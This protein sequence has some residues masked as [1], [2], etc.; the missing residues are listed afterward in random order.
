MPVPLRGQEREVD[1]KLRECRDCRH[2]VS[3]SAPACPQCGAPFPAQANWNGWGFEYKSK[4]RLLGLP[5]VHVSFKYRPNRMPVV[6]CGW[7]AIGQFSGGIVNI[8]QFG[9]GPIAVSQF[10]LAGVAVAQF[11]VAGIALCQFGLAL[12][13]VGQQLIRLADLIK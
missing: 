11:C 12:D 13:G 3:R 7:L 8:S 5:L 10:A 4:L 1:A 9:V 6:A 2:E